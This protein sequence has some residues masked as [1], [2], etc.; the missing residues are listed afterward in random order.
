MDNDG[1]P[2]KLQHSKKE[3]MDLNI[4][5]EPSEPIESIFIKQ[6]IVDDQIDISTVKVESQDD[7]F[8]DPLALGNITTNNV[9][10][11]RG[12]LSIENTAQNEESVSKL[13]PN[14]EKNY[15]TETMQI[16]QESLG[17]SGIAFGKVRENTAQDEVNVSKF[18]YK[19]LP[20]VKNVHKEFLSIVKEGYQC[21]ICSEIMNPKMADFLF[22]IKSL[23][24]GMKCELCSK[25]F[26]NAGN[27]QRHIKKV[28][29]GINYKCET[30][31][32]V[33]CDAGTLKRHIDSI[34]NGVKNHKC[35]TCG[36]AFSKFGNLKIHVLS[37]HGS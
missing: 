16:F 25:A 5:S 12:F 14:V 22:H 37:V 6:E 35:D 34:H 1:I 2:S 29:G 9:N 31:E 11:K 33:Y 32:K 3:Q 36:K 13:F 20:N 23:H 30:C 28:H 24:Y 4:K 18:C 15:S 19:S 17:K 8:I 7:S 27:L 26:S 21:N 10:T